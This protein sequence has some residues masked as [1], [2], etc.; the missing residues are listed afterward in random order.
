ML[1]S[2]SATSFAWPVSHANLSG[3]KYL[4]ASLSAGIAGLNTRRGTA[5]QSTVHRAMEV[6]RV[7]LSIYVSVR[8]GSVFP[9]IVVVVVV[10]LTPLDSARF[11]LR[12]FFRPP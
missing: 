5:R 9:A 8:R 4:L 10:L 7:R 6:S 3:R 2:A 1:S 11:S 12:A